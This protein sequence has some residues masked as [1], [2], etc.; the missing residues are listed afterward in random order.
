MNARFYSQ[1][2]RAECS[3]NVQTTEYSDLERAAIKTVSERPELLATILAD[4]SVV[5]ALDKTCAVRVTVEIQQIHAPAVNARAASGRGKTLC[6]RSGVRGGNVTC[7]HCIR[8]MGREVS[9]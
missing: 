7:K 1:H 4:D 5:R 2:K 3:R 6:G 9:A 8:K